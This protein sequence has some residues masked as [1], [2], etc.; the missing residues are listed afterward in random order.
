[1]IPVSIPSIPLSDIREGMFI[2]AYSGAPGAGI[3]WTGRALQVAHIEGAP[4]LRMTV[5][6]RLATLMVPDES[7]LTIIEAQEPL[8]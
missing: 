3:D 4:V 7:V 6:G 2:R 5:D 1:M 8:S